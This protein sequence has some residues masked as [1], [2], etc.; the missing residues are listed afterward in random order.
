MS[1][2]DEGTGREGEKQ[3]L[4]S[5]VISQT[6]DFYITLHFPSYFKESHPLIL[7]PLDHFRSL[8]HNDGA[9]LAA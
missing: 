1:L 3:F 6:R 8:A 2:S 4:C 7:L 9:D 5:Q